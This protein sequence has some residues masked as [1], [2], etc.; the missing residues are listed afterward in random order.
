MNPRFERIY[1]T[2]S[3]IP[4]GRVC[5]YGRVAAE[6]G[7]PRRARLVATALRRLPRG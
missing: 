5:S 2:V 1:E 4:E 7:L 6:A 3:S